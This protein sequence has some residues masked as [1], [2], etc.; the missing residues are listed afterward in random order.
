MGSQN[1]PQWGSNSSLSFEDK[2][3]ILHIDS[4]FIAKKVAEMIFE[5]LSGGRDYGH[6]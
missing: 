5:I 6:S 3:E 2:A 1:Y 4:S